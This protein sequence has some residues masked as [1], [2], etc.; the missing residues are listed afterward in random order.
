AYYQARSPFA[1][2]KG[3][4]RSWWESIPKENREGIR[5]PAIVLASVVPHSADVEHLFSALGGIQTPRR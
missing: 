5:T 4:A 3:D 2:G 1:G